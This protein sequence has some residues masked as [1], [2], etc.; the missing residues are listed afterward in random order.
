MGART[1][2]TLLFTAADITC[3]EFVAGDLVLGAYYEWNKETDERKIAVGLNSWGFKDSLRLLLGGSP[4]SLQAK[5]L[6][7][8]KRL[9][10]RTVHELRHAVDHANDAFMPIVWKEVLPGRGIRGLAHY[11]TS[12]YEKRARNTEREA[13]S[14]PNIISI[15]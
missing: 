4:P 8:E 14:Y 6:S 1:T 15:D 11:S 7:P 13:S 5:K 12:T 9:H 10:K 3:D 2:A